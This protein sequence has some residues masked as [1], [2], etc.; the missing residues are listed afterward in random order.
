MHDIE[1]N[2]KFVSFEFFGFW[3]YRGY[4]IIMCDDHE[5]NYF[6]LLYAQ[7]LFEKYNF[8]TE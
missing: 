3:Y 7:V 1:N 5:V 8:S 6:Y 2:F 4:Y